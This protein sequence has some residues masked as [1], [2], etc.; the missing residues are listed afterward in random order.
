MPP[1]RYCYRHGDC[2]AAILRVSVCS[3]T[4]IS[5]HGQPQTAASRQ[6]QVDSESESELQPASERLGL[7][8][9]RSESR[10][11]SKVQ[12]IIIFHVID[13]QSAN[14]SHYFTFSL[15]VFAL[16]CFINFS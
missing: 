11:I 1:A 8:G 12:V 2:R 9:V 14:Y 4:V 6:V 13:F 3:G 5:S 7:L 16:L 15:L 10:D